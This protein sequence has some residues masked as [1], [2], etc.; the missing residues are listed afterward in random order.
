MLSDFRGPEEKP[1]CLQAQGVQSSNALA[2]VSFYP[3][4]LSFLAPRSASR[5]IGPGMGEK[6]YPAGACGAIGLSFRAL[7]RFVFK[8]RSTNLEMIHIL[9]LAQ[10]QDFH[11]A[12][13]FLLDSQTLP[14]Y[15]TLA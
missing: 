8:F 5:K 1:A 10:W 13:E 4:N 12:R 3:L 15:T 9:N 14:F 6:G 11:G 2:G 7:A